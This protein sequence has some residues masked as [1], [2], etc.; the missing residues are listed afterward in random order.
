MNKSIENHKQ[1]IRTDRNGTKYYEVY[2]I[3]SRCGGTGVWSN[4][5][6]KGVCFGCNGDGHKGLTT[7]K[8]YTPEHEAKL[9]RRRQQREEKKRQAWLQSDEY[10]QQQERKARQEKAMEE[11]AAKIEAEN[12]KSDFVGNVKERIDVEVTI[13]KELRFEGYYGMT[14]LYIMKDADDNKFTW[15]T[16]SGLYK[17]G[18]DPFGND[19]EVPCEEGDVVKIRGTVKEHKVYQG[20]KQTVLTRVKQQ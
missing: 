20:E 5:M 17:D 16:Q 14:S 9:E 11:R 6:T 12:A 10:K 7:I 13:E 15:F 3:C 8:E 1:Y 2:K 4:G 19:K 18:Q